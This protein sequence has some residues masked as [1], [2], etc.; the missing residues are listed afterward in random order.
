MEEQNQN[1]INAVVGAMLI[2]QASYIA[3]DAV[4]SFNDDTCEFFIKKAGK[5]EEKLKIFCLEKAISFLHTK[6]HLELMSEWILKESDKKE[7]YFVL[8]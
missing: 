3:P 7:D 5:S 2:A 8:T 1:L 4:E 6:K